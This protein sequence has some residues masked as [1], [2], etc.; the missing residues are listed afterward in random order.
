MGRGHLWFSSYPTTSDPGG[1]FS[2]MPTFLR[3]GAWASSQLPVSSIPVLTSLPSLDP[4]GGRSPRVTSGSK[5]GSTGSESRAAASVDCTKADRVKLLWDSRERPQLRYCHARPCGQAPTN[6]CGAYTN[7]GQSAL[8]LFP[9]PA[10]SSPGSPNP[11]PAQ[12]VAAVAFAA[13]A[14]GADSGIPAPG[15]LRCPC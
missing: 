9:S 4:R 8:A 13:A 7:S 5:R 6:H 14:S 3:S 2:K 10:R 12:A 1:N 11:V 15:S